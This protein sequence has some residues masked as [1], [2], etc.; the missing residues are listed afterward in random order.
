MFTSIPYDEGW[1]IYANGEKIIPAKVLDGLIGFYL[2]PGEYTL[3][4]R[5]WPS[6]L[7][8]GLIGSALGLCAFAA[9]WIISVQKRKSLLAQGCPVYV[10]CDLNA[11]AIQPEAPLA[12]AFSQLSLETEEIPQALSDTDQPVDTET[13]EEEQP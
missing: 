8:I 6:C 1:N 3:E 12:E 2:E 7:T 4:L 10:P 9:A 11:E 5:Y 13:T